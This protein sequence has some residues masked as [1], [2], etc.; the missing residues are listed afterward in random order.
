MR[1]RCPGNRRLAA[2]ALCAG[3]SGLLSARLLLGALVTLAAWGAGAGCSGLRGGSADTDRGRGDN[4]GAG[5]VDMR[6]PTPQCM[7]LG[8]QIAQCPPAGSDTV[9]TGRITAPNGEDPIRDAIIYVPESGAPEEFPPQVAC[10][11]CNSPVGGRP[12]ALTHSGIDG[13]F[14]LSR[15]PVTDN[16]PIVIQ[17]GR[18]RKTV[19]VPISKCERQGLSAEQTRLPR[20][21]TEGTLPQMAVAVGDYDSIEC[22]LKNIGVAPSEFTSPKKQGAIHLY[23]NE[24]AG[25]GAPGKVNVGELLRSLPA[26]RQYNLI[27][28]NCSETTYSGG[29]LADSQVKQN[30]VD[31]VASGGRLYATDWSYDF[32]QQPPSFSPYICFEDDQACTVTTPHGFHTAPSRGAGDTPFDADVDTSTEA[33]Q[34]LAAWLTKLPTPVLGGKVHIQDLLPEWV[35]IH[36]TA[37]DLAKFPSTTWLNGTVKGRKRPLSVT[38]DYPQEMACGKVL[39]SSYH[40]REHAAQTL[41]PGYCASGKMITQEHVLE[42]L[43]FELSSCVGPIG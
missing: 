19:H 33:G 25:T 3:G 13:T 38:F 7:G 26:M 8:C 27:F 21:R 10:E 2:E 23:D 14:E 35:L 34:N 29:L 16:T 18:W 1:T 12:V 9:V 5:G 6:T 39:Y 17:K 4:P 41:F 32:V 31:Y 40:T 42:Y 37:L 11:V 28:L 20:D 24:T 22:V 43:I 30:L 15:V 36:Q